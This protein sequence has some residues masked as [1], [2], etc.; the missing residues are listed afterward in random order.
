MRVLDVLERVDPVIDRE[1]GVAGSS[2]R[3][4]VETPKVSVILDDEYDSAIPTHR[5]GF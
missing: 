2:K 4:P 5:R 3:C 1:N